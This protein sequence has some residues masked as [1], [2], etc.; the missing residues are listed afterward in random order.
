VISDFR[1][2]D[3]AAGGQGALLAPSL[4][5]IFP[6]V[7]F[8]VNLGGIANL[9]YFTRR[10]SAHGYSACESAP[11][12]SRTESGQPYD[13]GGMLARNGRSMKHL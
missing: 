1:S 11:E 4:S 7:Y 13:N 2:N 8:Y 12:F 5:D 9:S 10:M 3:I 6:G